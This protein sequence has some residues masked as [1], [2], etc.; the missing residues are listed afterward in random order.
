MSRGR[1]R[2]RRVR[3]VAKPRL[4]YWN[5]TPRAT[6]SKVGG[7]RATC[8]AG[9]L[10]ESKNLAPAPSTRSLWIERETSGSEEVPGGTASKNLRAMESFSGTL[11]IADQERRQ[12]SKR[13][14]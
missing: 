8:P 5:S 2:H 1:Q 10:R 11:V 7:A 3:T 4:R 13:S 6:F 14:L 9:R 12:G